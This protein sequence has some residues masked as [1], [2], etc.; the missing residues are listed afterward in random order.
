MTGR[1]HQ[2]DVLLVVGAGLVGCSAALAARRLGWEV[3]LH[4]LDPGVLAAAVDGEQ[5]G[6]GCRR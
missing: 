1:S 3:W 4:D 6:R 2:P 5:D